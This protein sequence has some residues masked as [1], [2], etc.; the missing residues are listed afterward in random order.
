MIIHNINPDLLVIGTVH[1]RYYGLVYF[2][3]FL[4]IY[5]FLRYAIS[6]QK[7]K[8]L[9]NDR[10]DEFMLYLII[11]SIFFAR[12]FEFIFY[13]PQVFFNNPLEFF[14]IWN[15]GMSIHGGIFG[16]MFAGYFFCKKYNVSF[17]KMADLI[18]IPLMFF[19]AIG[20]IANYINGELWGKVTT[21]SFC[22]DYSQSQYVF[23][24]P[25]GCRHPYQLY[26]SA[27]NFLVAFGMLALKNFTKLKTGLLFWYSMFFYNAL[28][29]FVDFTREIQVYVL[30]MDM[31]QVLSII[32]ALISLYFIIKIHMKK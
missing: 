27:K 29:L 8:N 18:A 26:A 9:N 32:Y 23:N 1:I 13:I 20:R 15:G 14:S 17:F 28:R 3:G 19:L 12:L 16:A 10:L 31:G 25:Q 24:P 4:F 30:G 11:G 21:S 7:V 5:F 6:K 2:L 22:V